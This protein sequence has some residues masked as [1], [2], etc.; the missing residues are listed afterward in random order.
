MR[1]HAAAL[2]KDVAARPDTG[3]ACAAYRV[4]GVTHWFA[5]EY[6]EAR[7]NLERGLAMFQPGRD[8]D[9]A[10][11]FGQDVGVAVMLFLANVTWPLGDVA[12]AIALSDRAQE[13]IESTPHANTRAFGKLHTAIFELTSGELSRA[14]PLAWEL[15]RIARE[16]DLP[17]FRAVAAF[18][19]A[20][21]KSHNGAPA[22]ARE[23]MSRAAE[24]LR[25]QNVRP[26]D[27]PLKIAH[28]QAEA[29][30]GNPGR[31]ISILDE[32]LAD[33]RCRGYCAYEAELHR[34]RG[35]ILLKR[36]PKNL[37]PAG[38]ALQT[39]IAVA[40][41][42]GTRSFELRA[43]LSLAKLYQSI[44]R[45]TEAHAVL[46]PAVEGFAPTLQMPEIAE[47]QGLLE[48]FAYGDEGP[49]WRATECWRRLVHL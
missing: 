19:E 10:F 9:L 2:L 34:V 47:A 5:G 1:A 22:G 7:E 49:I 37:G 25:E 35:E 12:R 13:R 20:W 8:D 42:Q 43:A 46:V 6:R 36:D 15:A 39:A 23:E 45:P 41:Q 29:R 4:A 48:R 30:I 44:A 17:M 3:E 28:A 32:A 16:H 33:F 21:A 11:H 18:F 27:G 24:L 14:V 26:F 40:R 38:E 31:A